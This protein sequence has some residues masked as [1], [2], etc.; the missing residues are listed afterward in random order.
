MLSHVN[1]PHSHM[2]FIFLVNLKRNRSGQ[3]CEVSFKFS[4]GIRGEG[5]EEAE[6]SLL[7]LPGWVLLCTSLRAQSVNHS[8]TY[9]TNCWL[10]TRPQKPAKASPKISAK[11]RNL[12]SNGQKQNPYSSCFPRHKY[13]LERERLRE[14]K[15]VKP[16]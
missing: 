8:L 5:F 14:K 9:R 11:H 2:H 1:Y 13:R 3:S 10:S 4:R 15:G 7:L 16:A 6:P 12:H